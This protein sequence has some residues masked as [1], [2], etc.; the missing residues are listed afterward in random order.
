[1]QNEMKP[2]LVAYQHGGSEWNVSI[3]AE[4]FSDAR[5]RLGKLALGR[6]EGELIATIPNGFGPFAALATFVQNVTRAVR[7]F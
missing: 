3:M 4:S 7:R 2:F 5:D 6:V 1:M